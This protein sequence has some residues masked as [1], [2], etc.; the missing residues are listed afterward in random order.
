MAV[1]WNSKRDCFAI[2]P[3]GGEKS[4]IGRGEIRGWK[5]RFPGPEGCFWAGVRCNGQ[6][7]LA[8]LPMTSSEVITNCSILQLVGAPD[9]LRR[10]AHGIVG[11]LGHHLDDDLVVLDGQRLD[12]DA[13]TQQRRGDVDP[14]AILLLHHGQVVEHAAAAGVGD[15]DHGDARRTVQLACGRI[16]EQAD[17]HLVRCI[18]VFAILK[19]D[20]ADV[21]NRVGGVE[22]FRRQRHAAGGAT[23]ASRRASRRSE[24]TAE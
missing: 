18:L 19:R 24:L 16:R 6:L 8:T 21:G 3:G 20:R 15:E 12:V 1:D 9:D 22:Q 13:V 7:P 4:R 11:T 5:S 10:T 17:R 23:G 14:G 2:I